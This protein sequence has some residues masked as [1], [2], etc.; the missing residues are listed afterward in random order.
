MS[1]IAKQAWYDYG[2]EGGRCCGFAA[3]YVNKLEAELSI[4]RKALERIASNEAF[5]TAGTLGHGW[6]DNECRQRMRVAAEALD[7]TGE[8]K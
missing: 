5:G 1:E 6:A 7:A 3:N 4:C 8:K 2:P